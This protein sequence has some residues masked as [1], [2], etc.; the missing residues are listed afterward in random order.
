MLIIGDRSQNE[1]TP[2]PG[3]KRREL[4]KAGGVVLTAATL[5]FPGQAEAKRMMQGRE[6]TMR[7]AHTGQ[8][9]KGEYWHNG[10]YVPDAFSEIKQVMKDHRANKT[11]PI[12]PRLMDILFV[13]QKRMDNT[14]PYDIFSGYR[15]HETNEK[16]RRMSFGVAKKSLHMLGQA[17]D[18]RLP[19]SDLGKVRKQA[20]SLKAGGVGYYPES[21]FLH[22][23]TGRIR[24][25]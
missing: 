9:F 15:S 24:Q 19:G 22:V 21:H 8:V 20:I 3:I 18:L 25:W 10:S 2:I 13:L 17:V 23:D 4:I 7:N 5:W 1:D 16:L 14:K 11:F 6:I 12:D